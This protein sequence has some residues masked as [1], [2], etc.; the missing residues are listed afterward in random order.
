MPL[1]T[2]WACI[3]FSS[4]SVVHDFTSKIVGCFAM[5]FKD[6]MFILNGYG[7]EMWGQW[8]TEN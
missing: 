1:T 5:V 3:C 7:N 8:Q 2:N 6:F 4:L